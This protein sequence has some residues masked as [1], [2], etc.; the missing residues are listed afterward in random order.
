VP[1]QDCAVIHLTTAAARNVIKRENPDSGSQRWGS[2]EHNRCRAQVGTRGA[3]DEH[4]I[5]FEQQ[6][7]SVKDGLDD[8]GVQ[9]L[10]NRRATSAQEVRDPLNA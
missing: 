10:G 1:V 4:F 2:F 5:N 3:L 8:D 6:D 7:D 9:P